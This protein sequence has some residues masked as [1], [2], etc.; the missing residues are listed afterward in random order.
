MYPARVKRTPVGHRAVVG[1]TTA[2]GPGHS[3]PPPHARLHLP[4]ATANT[5]GRPGA[6]MAGTGSAG[7][8][9]AQRLGPSVLPAPGRGC[10]A[11]HTQNA[12]LD[13]PSTCIE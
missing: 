10:R 3:E 11:V 8:R 2:H 13:G 6:H 9:P 1:R 12:R 7:R 5:G 4:G